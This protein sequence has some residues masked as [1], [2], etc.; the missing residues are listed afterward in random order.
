MS[1]LRTIEDEIRRVFGVSVNEI[2]GGIIHRFH[3][4]PERV[5][6]ILHQEGGHRL[7][8]TA[9]FGFGEVT[10][11]TKINALARQRGRPHW[12]HRELGGRHGTGPIQRQLPRPSARTSTRRPPLS[13]RSV[14]P[15]AR[16]LRR[17]PRP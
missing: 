9:R 4:D 11:D 3:R 1:T 15:S 7:P 17:A 13:L 8:H 10:L 12:L 2:L 16:S 14:P 5:E 6:R